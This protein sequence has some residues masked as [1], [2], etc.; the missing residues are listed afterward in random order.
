MDAR[1]K[2]TIQRKKKKKKIGRAEKKMLYS[3]PP[4]PFFHPDRI[5]D[6]TQNLAGFVPH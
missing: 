4:G 1:H 5:F 2:K 3:L 6:G